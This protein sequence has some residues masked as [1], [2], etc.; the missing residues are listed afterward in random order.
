[1]EGAPSQSSVSA[2]PLRPFGPAHLAILGLVAASGA[3]AWWLPRRRPGPWRRTRWTLAGLSSA[4]G[5]GWYV[6]RV[7]ALHTSR[8]LALP[9]ELCDAALWITVAALL[10]PRQRLLELAYYWGLPG[11]SMALLTPYLVAPLLSVPSVTFLA[12]HALIIIAVLFLLGTGRRPRP[13]S[14]LFALLALNAFAAFDYLTDRLLGANY[15]YLVHKPPIRSLLS[16][17]GPWPWYILLGDAFTAALFFA[18]NL[19][20]RRQAE[21]R[22]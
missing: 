2:P 10:W 12:G 8:R 13:G 15:M 22:N 9:L 3:L 20:F 1:M 4:L 7:V 6:F 17:M 21:A 14:W 19:P 5:G 18:L 11:A 16:V